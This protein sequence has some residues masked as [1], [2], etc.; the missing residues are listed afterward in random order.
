MK[1]TIFLIVL[2]WA[3]A[4]F[5]LP[6]NT[7]TTLP[8]WGDILDKPT[9]IAGYGITDAAGLQGATGPKGDKGDTGDT[10]PQGIQGIQGIQGP[11]GDTG[12]TGP[13]GATGATGAT[14]DTGATGPAGAA[15]AGQ[16]YKVV[17]SNITNSTTNPANIT[18]LSFSVAANTEYGFFCSITGSGS[19]TA[20]PRYNITGPASP[21]TVSFMTQ[22]ATTTSAQTLLVLQAFSSAAQTAACTSSCNTTVLPMLIYGT[23]LNGSNAGT[24]QLQVTSSTSGQTVTV[25]RGSYCVVY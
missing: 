21:T 9:T 25:Y 4:A 23:I 22:R 7:V 18:G 14:G 24:V 15:G 16:L 10:G 11:K 19:S 20:L 12:D 2:L 8:V 13:Q 6:P 17:T 5:A 1:K 3:S